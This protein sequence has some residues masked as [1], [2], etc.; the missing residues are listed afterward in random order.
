[1]FGRSWIGMD[2]QFGEVFDAIVIG[3][4]FGGC[5]AALPLVQAGLRVLMLERGDWVRRGVENWGEQGAF[6]LTP[7]YSVE[8]GFSFRGTGGKWRPQGTVTNVGGPSVFYGGA[9]F[10]FREEDFDPPPEISPDG[11][12]RWP[13]D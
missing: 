8:S 2:Q 4:G 11:D 10:R 12:A 5:M 3:S 1:L 9:S 6:V 7:H 13:I